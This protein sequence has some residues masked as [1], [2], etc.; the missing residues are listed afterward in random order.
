MED[1]KLDI[2]RW[3]EIQCK[4]RKDNKI[5]LFERLVC[6]DSTSYSV[7]ASE[8]HLCYPRETLDDGKYLAVEVY[9]GE[10]NKDFPAEYELSPYTYSYI[11]IEML[12]EILDTHGGIVEEQLRD[13][14]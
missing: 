12:Q 3:L 6:N 8:Y 9:T 7:Q 11:P 10:D 1:K 5:R 14:N 4:K 2:E 13:G